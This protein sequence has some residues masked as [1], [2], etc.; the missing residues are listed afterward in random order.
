M[1]LFKPSNLTPN[2]ESVVY[3]QPL[4]LTFQVNSNGSR[5]TAYRVQILTDFNDKDDPDK[6]IIG[7]IYGTFNTPLYNKDIGEILLTQ[8]TLK[9]NG[10]ELE[11]NK[12]YR[13]T[14]RLYGE[15]KRESELVYNIVTTNVGVSNAIEAIDFSKD[16][17]IESSN[18][19]LLTNAFG[20]SAS[21]HCDIISLIS[22]RACICRL[23]RK[24]KV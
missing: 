7:T 14:L 6:N 23:P 2:F 5:V 13:W 19:N 1:S 15:D 10:I 3:N 18:R 8:E 24:G 20:V 22:N 21:S 16:F 11:P 4:T 17:V 9:Y 12:D